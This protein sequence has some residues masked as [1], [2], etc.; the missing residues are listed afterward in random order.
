LYLDEIGAAPDSSKVGD[1]LPDLYSIGLSDGVALHLNRLMKDKY[2]FID[3]WG[4]WCR[5]CIAALPIL[6]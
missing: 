3:F 4:S 6:K 5:P 1:Y 2:V